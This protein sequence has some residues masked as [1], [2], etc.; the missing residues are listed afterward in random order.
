MY[1]KI[2]SEVKRVKN[3]LRKSMLIKRVTLGSQPLN[4]DTWPLNLTFQSTLCECHQDV[5]QQDPLRFLPDRTLHAG[6]P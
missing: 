6:C 4:E 5:W 3:L 2:F 1:F